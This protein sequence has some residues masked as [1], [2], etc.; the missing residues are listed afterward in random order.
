MSTIPTIKDQGTID[1]ELNQGGV[2]VQKRTLPTDIKPHTALT[3]NRP[4]SSTSAS[5]FVNPSHVLQICLSSMI[6]KISLHQA[7]TT[8]SIAKSLLKPDLA[9]YSRKLIDLSGIDGSEKAIVPVRLIE[10]IR[11]LSPIG[12][13]NHAV[14]QDTL[15]DWAQLM[16]ILDRDLQAEFMKRVAALQV[17]LHHEREKERQHSETGSSSKPP[18]THSEANDVKIQE[19]HFVCPFD[20]NNAVASNI[21]KKKHSQRYQKWRGNGT[22][23]AE[24]S[25]RTGR[26]ILVAAGHSLNRILA[27]N[28]TSKGQVS[29]FIHFIESLLPEVKQSIRLFNRIA[30]RLIVCM[31]SHTNLDHDAEIV[32]LLRQDMKDV[33]RKV[34]CA[35]RAQP[36]IYESLA[37][38]EGFPWNPIDSY[39]TFA[40]RLFSVIPRMGEAANT[41]KHTFSSGTD[42]ATDLE[43]KYQILPTPMRDLK[44][45]SSSHTRTLENCRASHSGKVILPFYYD[46]RWWLVTC[47]EYKLIMF[48]NENENSI[49]AMDAIERFM[50]IHGYAKQKCL[51]TF[52]SLSAMFEESGRLEVCWWIAKELSYAT[53]HSTSK[54]R[55]IF[56]EVDW[57]HVKILMASAIAEFDHDT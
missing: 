35:T 4:P 47:D 7:V 52:R 55:Y 46:S 43:P 18:T 37:K 14:N 27:D 23:L 56:K 28:R 34:P 42:Q 12:K 33:G 25:N 1:R 51:R 11:E 22:R 29:A 15:T 31:T 36:N 54:D 10:I 53:S 57:C 6:Y 38:I 39:L 2:L 20:I 32:S 8:Y 49:R 3:T 5:S 44:E 40:N 48:D 24:I 30:E 16:A 26:G 45:Q 19:T 21:E 41:L 9:E 17:H 13:A 50:S